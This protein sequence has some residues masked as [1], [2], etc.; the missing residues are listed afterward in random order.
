MKLYNRTNGA[1]A[2][3]SSGT[4]GFGGTPITICSSGIFV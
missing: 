4:F 1:S 2:V 3:P